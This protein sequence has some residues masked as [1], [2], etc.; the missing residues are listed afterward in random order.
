MI[1]RCES[2]YVAKIFVNRFGGE[3]RGEEYHAPEDAEVSEVRE[4]NRNLPRFYNDNG[5]WKPIE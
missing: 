5:T 2:A 3:V 4:F 1:I